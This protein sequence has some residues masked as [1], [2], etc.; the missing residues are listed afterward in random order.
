MDEP[1]VTPDREASG[2]VDQPA[3]SLPI[4]RT[5]PVLAVLLAMVAG[6]VDAHLYLHLTPVFVANMSGNLIRIG[7]FSTGSHWPEAVRAAVAVAAFLTGVL[8]AAF[9]NRR[10][11]RGGREARAATLLLVESAL[12]V[13]ASVW[14][15]LADLGFSRS[16]RFADLPLVALAAIAMGVQT[17]A[18][19]RTGQLAVITTFETGTIVRVGERV[20]FRLTDEPEGRGP[21]RWD[22]LSVLVAV[23]VGYVAGAVV[24]ALV[25]SSHLVLVGPAAVL[26]VVAGLTTSA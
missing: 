23:V 16:V 3:G 14:L 9:L 7:M 18:M 22:G 11:V 25:G 4:G 21:R 26:A 20:V 17:E 1:A 24:A 15:V 8:S 5:S 19:R 13:L 10:R 6:F 12:I 2:A